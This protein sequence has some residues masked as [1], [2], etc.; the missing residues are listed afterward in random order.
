M[1]TKPGDIWL[2]V[3]VEADPDKYLLGQAPKTQ[4]ELMELLARAVQ[5]VTGTKVLL[6]TAES[7]PYWRFRQAI[8]AVQAAGV[9]TVRLATAIDQP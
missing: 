7:T 2:R 5:S 3:R 1:P 4:A 9:G 6:V 8:D